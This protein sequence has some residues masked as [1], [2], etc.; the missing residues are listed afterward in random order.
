MVDTWN[1]NN[2]WSFEAK[3]NILQNVKSD[4]FTSSQF[5]DNWPNDESM[6]GNFEM[7]LER[8]PNIY[9]AYYL[10][11]I[12]R[13]LAARIAVREFSYRNTELAHPPSR[14]QRDNGVII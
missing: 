5:H 6:R 7:F 12:E 3:P 11:T 13:R 9:R 4:V 8:T 14:F 2:T 1:D 10:A